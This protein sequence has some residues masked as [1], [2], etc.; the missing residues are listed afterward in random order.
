MKNDWMWEV[1]WFGFFIDCGDDG[2]VVRFDLVD[3]ICGE[4]L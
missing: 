1:F 2:I 3:D 4:I